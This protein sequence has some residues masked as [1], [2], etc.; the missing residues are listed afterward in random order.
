M[1]LQGTRGAHARPRPDHGWG[2]TRGAF[3]LTTA[4][5]FTAAPLVFPAWALATGTPTLNGTGVITMIHAVPGLVA[6]VSVDGT[7]IL[8]GFTASRVTDP[9]TLS[10]GIHTV[11]LKADNGPSAGKT[12]LTAKLNVVAGTTSTAVVGL[13]VD[14]SP[15]AFVFPETSVPVPG[16]KAAVVV[17]QVAASPPVNLVVNGVTLPIGAL[18]NG[19]SVTKDAVPGSYQVVAKSATGQVELK[20]QPA[21]IQADRIT[22]L[23]LTGSRANK[24]LG[25]VA[26]TR[27]ASSLT[28]LSTVPT[29]DGSTAHALMTV[30]RDVPVGTAAIVALVTGGAAGLISRS[31]AR[32]RVHV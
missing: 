21:M 26:T 30:R 19:D 31:R 1:G 6:D 13:A 25:W 14:G 16:G 15:K 32:R 7:P 5:V 28:A 2:K 3:V 29:G 20:A 22:T 8:T 27:L 12:V 4:V 11:S 23:Y 18:A 17:R 10:A 9:V 24:S